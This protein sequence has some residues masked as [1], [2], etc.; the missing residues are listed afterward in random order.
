MA[1]SPSSVVADATTPSPTRGKGR[2]FGAVIDCFD[3]VARMHLTKD[4]LMIGRL[5]HVAIAVADLEAGEEAE[6]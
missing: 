2:A 6:V 5:N 4:A 3:G 1:R